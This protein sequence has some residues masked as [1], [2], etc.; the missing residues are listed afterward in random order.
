MPS[1][2]YIEPNLAVKLE[3][4]E[5]WQQPPVLGLDILWRS[6]LT[7]DSGNALSFSQFS[8]TIPALVTSSRLL[9]AHVGPW[10]EHWPKTEATLRLEPSAPPQRARKVQLP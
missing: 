6:G 7:D 2:N 8:I 3:K 9:Q 4:A 1:E 5:R 10:P